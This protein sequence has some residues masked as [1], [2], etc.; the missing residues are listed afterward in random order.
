M[1]QSIPSLDTFYTNLFLY[2]FTPDQMGPLQRHTQT[3]R[4]N[5]LTIHMSDIT[6][7]HTKSKP[8]RGTNQMAGAGSIIHSI[9]LTQGTIIADASVACVNL[10]SCKG[11]TCSWRRSCSHGRPRRTPRPPRTALLRTRRRWRRRWPARWRG[12]SLPSQGTSCRSCSLS[13]SHSW[14]HSCKTSLSFA[15]SSTA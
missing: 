15:V 4:S 9:T 3:Q 2:I 6:P 14:I 5:S 10:S 11:R 13:R 7:N 8:H 1:S 12:S